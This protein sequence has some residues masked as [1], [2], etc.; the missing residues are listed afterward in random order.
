MNNSVPQEQLATLR[1]SIDQIDSRLI[2]LLNERARLAIEIGNA[3]RSAGEPI[4]TPEREQQILQRVQAANP[5][6]L[7]NAA[8]EG[9]F[10]AIIHESAALE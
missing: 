7:S 10:R 2:E 6:P 9:L 3:K 4:L 5:G 1:R 8:L